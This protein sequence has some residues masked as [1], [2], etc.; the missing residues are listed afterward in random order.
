MSTPPASLPIALGSVLLVQTV[1]AVLWVGA[2]S[3][4]LAQLE[5]HQARMSALEVRAAR[6][7]EQTLHL[8]DTML[9]I[10]AK[11]DRALTEDER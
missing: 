3:N 10:E 6:L 5:A 11:L 7:E 1:T 4:R 8:R 2:A 9:R